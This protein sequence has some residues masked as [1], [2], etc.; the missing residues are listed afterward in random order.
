MAA[1]PDAYPGDMTSL[2]PHLP[3]LS[4]KPVCLRP[5]SISGWVVERFESLIQQ[6]VILASFLT[7]LVGG[8]G[9]SSGQTV[10]ELVKRLGMREIEPR[11]LPRVLLRELMIGGC[12]AIALGLATFPRVRLLS[13]KASDLDALVRDFNTPSLCD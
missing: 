10:A 8:G 3:Y 9:N 7:M 11:Q 5:Q 4:A 12:L 6:H 13:K 1:H 2:T